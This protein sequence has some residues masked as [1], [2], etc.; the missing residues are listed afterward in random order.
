MPEQ[1]VAMR[2]GREMVHHRILG[3]CPGQSFRRTL[4]F[5]MPTD[6]KD[7][8]DS[9]DDQDHLRGVSRNIAL[10][11]RNFKIARRLNLKGNHY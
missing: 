4:L 10:A 2:I 8:R 9:R 3:A 6:S 7:G 11:S 5:A 1:S